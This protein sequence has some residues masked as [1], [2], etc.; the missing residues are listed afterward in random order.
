MAPGAPSVRRI[1]GKSCQGT[2]P[3]KVMP[4]RNCDV[5]SALA[6][7]AE[8]VAV[9][10]GCQVSLVGGGSEV[11]LTVPT[12]GCKEAP[13]PAAPRAQGPVSGGPQGM[14]ERLVLFSD[15][16]SA[17]S[18]TDGG[19]QPGPVPK[20]LQKQRRV[21]ERLVSSECEYGLQS[22][23][24]DSFG[25]AVRPPSRA[26]P[27]LLGHHSTCPKALEAGRT[28]H[29][30]PSGAVGVLGS[31]IWTLPSR[32]TWLGAK[33][34]RA[35]RGQCDSPCRAERWGKVSASGVPE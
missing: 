27:P 1:R 3:A 13:G 21:L 34:D 30:S 7:S 17:L 22:C 15:S 26:P 14:W 33:R 11:A 10:P 32:S 28:S 24:C 19:A 4:T 5:S 18:L 29:P 25:P 20:S 31:G 12:K 35:Q 6:A 8:E 23:T 9:L 16:L 2:M